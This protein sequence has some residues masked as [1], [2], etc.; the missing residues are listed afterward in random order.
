M[1]VPVVTATG[2]QE[3]DG[4]QQVFVTATA[5]NS[6]TSWAF[7]SSVV[8]LLGSGNVR[9]FTAPPTYLGSTVTVTVTATNGSGTSTPTPVQVAVKPWSSFYLTPTGTWRPVGPATR[10]VAVAYRYVKGGHTGAETPTDVISGGPTGTGVP[11]LSGGG[12]TPAADL[13]TAGTAGSPSTDLYT[14][15]T[16]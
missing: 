10:V 11:I 8:A 3:V 9:W 1:P 5:T 16:A 15:G 12:A 6:P 4:F 13:V 14:G 2:P 7:T